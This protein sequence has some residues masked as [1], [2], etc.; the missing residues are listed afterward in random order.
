[1]QKEAHY[2]IYDIVHFIIKD[3]YDNSIT[4][5]LIIIAT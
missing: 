2:T 3:F 1:M 5:L 4:L